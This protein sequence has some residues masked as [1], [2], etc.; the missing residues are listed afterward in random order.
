M[1][2]L[3]EVV[4]A[5]IAMWFPYV[6]GATWQATVVALVAM[7]LVLLLHRRSA[8]LRYGLL[9]VALVKFAAPP[10]VPLPTGVFSHVSIPAIAIGGG[11]DVGGTA[12]SMASVSTTP[13]DAGTRASGTTVA[14]AG[15]GAS[16]RLAGIGWR[17]GLL[18]L[19]ACGGIVIAVLI[20]HYW[21]WLRRLVRASRE[22]TEAALLR[23]VHALGSHL[24][25]R[26]P[27][28]VLLAPETGPAL[29]TPVAFGFLRPT[30]VLPAALAPELNSAATSGVL[31]HELAHLRRKDMVVVWL[32]NLLLMVWWFNPVLWRLVR[33]LRAVREQCCD[34]LVVS[35]GVADNASYCDSLLSAAAC[36]GRPGRVKTALAFADSLHP[37]GGRIRRIMDATLKRSP[38]LSLAGV[39]AIA[40]VAALVLPGAAVVYGGEGGF[41]KPAVQSTAPM[42]YVLTMPDGAAM[43][44]AQRQ[45]SDTGLEVEKGQQLEFKAS[46]QVRGTQGP[47]EDWAYGPHGPGGVQHEGLMLA[48][49]GRVQGDDGA[50]EEFVIGEAARMAS[51][52]KGRLYLGVSDVVHEDNDGAF[53]VAV[54][55]DGKPVDFRNQIAKGEPRNLPR[56]P[57]TIAAP[58]AVAELPGTLIFE[59]AYVHKSRGYENPKPSKLWIK[60]REDGGLSVAA[61]FDEG[62]M[63]MVT[64]NTENRITQFLGIGE[65]YKHQLD[66]EDGKVLLTRRGIRADKDQAPLAVP[67]GAYFDPNS[68]PDMYVAANILLRRWN[69]QPGETREFDAYDWDNAGEGMAA[70]RLKVENKGKEAVQVPAGVFEAAHLVLTQTTSADTWFKKRAGH[71]TDFWVLDNGVIVRILRH[72]EPYELQLLEWSTPKELPGLKR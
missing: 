48:L 24:S 25:L 3:Q 36:A 64:A 60:Q 13:A 11:E 42:Q 8:P 4:K 44:S 45:W 46:G 58:A 47:P 23:Q 7:V 52:L 51:P 39:L 14:A 55:V 65:G 27:V 38:R 69:V 33:E 50:S 10:A 30:V 12:A 43:V 31:A 56:A 63:D 20:A 28:R 53:V 22:L 71:V 5:S 18:A 49:V 29:S 19:H 6:A 41:G 62:G 54:Q 9:L 35:L 72:R 32:E 40:G 37:L 2:G 59:G 66:I 67:P 1:G 16:S 61:R 68:R 34:D 26:R 21:L 70:Y 15:A 57:V 17:G